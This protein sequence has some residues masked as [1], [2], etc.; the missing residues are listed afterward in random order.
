MKTKLLSIMNNYQPTNKEKE[1]HDWLIDLLGDQK[2][3]IEQ[4]D[5][6]VRDFEPHSK[7]EKLFV[8]AFRRVMIE[9]CNPSGEVKPS[10]SPDI[11]H[12]IVAR[13]ISRQKVFKYK[14]LVEMVGS[15]FI[16]L[17]V[18]NK[19]IAEGVVARVGNGEYR[20]VTL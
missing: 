5:F 1:I 10:K 6:S 16:S 8:E 18:V 14:D 9:M 2:T 3:T 19:F 11:R 12:H 13:Y 7:E 4:I 15:K 20:N 17:R